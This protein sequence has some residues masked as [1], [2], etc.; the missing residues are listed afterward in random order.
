[1]IT[2][3]LL[4]ILGCFLAVPAFA[5][6]H[7][8]ASCSLAHVQAAVDASSSGDTV[9]VPAGACSWATQ[10]T[11]TLPITLQGA[12]A[13]DDTCDSETET[14]ITSSH[15]ES[16]N[17]TIPPSSTD[18]TF[19][20]VYKPAT[21]NKATPFRITGFFFDASST[22]TP[23]GKAGIIYVYH[24]YDD[25]T[26][27][28]NLRI[29]HNVFKGHGRS[30]TCY[31]EEL[32]FRGATYGVI[33]HNVWYGRPD[34]WVYG[35]ALAFK[36]MTAQRIGTDKA[37]FFEDN[38]FNINTDYTSNSGTM[39]IQVSNGGAAVIRY[40]TFNKTIT[41]GSSVTLLLLNMHGNQPNSAAGMF[42]EMYGNLF[43]DSQNE[44]GWLYN[45]RGGQS[46]IFYNQGDATT[47][48]AVGGHSIEHEPNSA[49]TLSYGADPNFGG[50]TYGNACAN[51]AE[52]LYPDG[53]GEPDS[54]ATTSLY[55]QPQHVWRTYIWNN[56]YGSGNT[57]TGHTGETTACSPPCTGYYTE[58]PLVE[59]LHWSRQKTT[60]CTAGG[61]CTTGVGCG[62]T[63]PTTCSTGTGFWLTSQ[64]CTSVDSTLVGAT[65]SANISGTFYRCTSQD[66]WLLYYTPYV[67][68]HPLRGESDTSAPAISG[69]SPTT[70]QQCTSDPRNVTLSLTAVDAT[71][72]IGCKYD[73]TSRAAYA[74]LTKDFVCG[75][76][77]TADCTATESLACGATHTIYY[78]CTDGTNASS[79]ANYSFA[80]ASGSDTTA[81]VI[82]NLTD[83]NQACG[84]VYLHISTDEQA[85][86]SY[87][88]SDVAYASMTPM[89]AGDTNHW[90]STVQQTC[91]TSTT[92]YFRCK[93]ANENTNLTSTSATV[94][95]GGAKTINMGSGSLTI[96]IGEGQ[97]NLQFTVIP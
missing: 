16:C 77:T 88:T 61:S 55:S 10:L 50:S 60:G 94:T 56:R 72:S 66:N 3:L 68:P 40:N 93:D 15:A 95:T 54:C 7:T 80:V 23:Y 32:Y 65:H 17:T 73:T 22:T 85:S 97:G 25:A 34:A 27:I 90:T 59:D 1:M 37:L 71:A 21:A 43:T 48:T 78:G 62:D 49:G 67:Y 20:V 36:N 35:G 26:P 28:T 53:D 82:T 74:D 41:A 51:T 83:A 79:V 4:L 76:G 86:C 33:D 45:L 63:L 64:G 70:T 92:Y 5:D 9:S 57:L 2:K 69:M 46:M 13:S 30:I 96:R 89:S 87:S 11:I 24:L 14:C 84:S 58:H 29:D 47:S 52:W 44:G 81:P 18:S 12:G 38:V 8:A 39:A 91:S 19:M 75:S 6:T 42:G 31:N